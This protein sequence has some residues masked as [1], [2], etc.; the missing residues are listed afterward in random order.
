MPSFS[1]TATS[2]EDT[3]LLTIRRS[4]IITLD[5]VFLLTGWCV[6]LGVP[7]LLASSRPSQ[8]FGE[9]EMTTTSAAGPS[10]DR[11]IPGDRQ[12]S[13]R[14]RPNAWLALAAILITA[15]PADA[16]QSQSSPADVLE[17][18]QPLARAGML[19]PGVH[20]YARYVIVDGARQLLDIWSRRLS[21]EEKNGKRLLHIVQRWD[22]ADKSYTAIFDQLFEATTFRPLSQS[23]SVTRNGAVKTLA[24]TF[25]GPNVDST[26]DGQAGA[27]KPLHEKFDMPFYNFHTDIEFIQ[28]LPLETGYVASIPFYDVGQEPPARYT[29]TVSGEETLAAADGT[30]IKCWLVLLQ[31]QEPKNPPTRFW[32]AQRNQVLVREEGTIPGQGT[33]VKTLLNA[34]AE[35]APDRQ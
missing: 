3:K 2:Y 27:A 16:T 19:V 13:L 18:G 7:P 32:F 34:E 35:D 22:A 5:D 30:P 25:D 12:S 15:M 26:S 33:L 14:R 24:V 29:F 20:R 23:Q 10:S 31:L 21:F 17:V 28:A 9:D 6:A 8:T 4:D 1:A 11:K